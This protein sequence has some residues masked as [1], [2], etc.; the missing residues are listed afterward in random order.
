MSQDL[1]T[2]NRQAIAAAKQHMGHISW[3][4]V[5]L[6]LIVLAGFITNL[7]LFAA[8]GDQPLGS[9]IDPGSVHLYV[10]YTTP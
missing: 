7:A 4:T 9:H 1:Q 3:P 8:G 10:L 6:V 2:L 5:G